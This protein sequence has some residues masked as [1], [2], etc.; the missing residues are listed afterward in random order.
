MWNSVSELLDS[1]RAELGAAGV[2]SWVVEGA[3]ALLLLLGGLLLARLVSAW[4]GRASAARLGVQQSL[5]L[6]R[7]VFLTLA[8]LFVATAL[9]QL[10]F[11]L[12][13]LLGAAGVLTVAVGFASQTSASN[14]ISGLFLISE[15]T[16]EVGDVIRVGAITGE[17]LAVDLLSVKLRRFDNTYVRIPN[18]KMI[19]SDVETLTRFRI[20]RI[21]L[22]LRVGFDEDIDAVRACLAAV[23][24]RHPKCL[25]EPAP[26]VQLKAFGESGLDVQLSVW[27]AKEN[28][29]E[30]STELHES[31]L[32][33]LRENGIRMPV[34]RRQLELTTPLSADR[35]E[36]QPSG[37][38]P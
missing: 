3:R 35:Y 37:D 16:F 27:V 26:L 28:F 24:R 12:S 34:P 22:L 25:S 1:L 7:G 31:V 23:P 5:L 38:G 4:V 9:K 20:R 21:D 6:K 15:R 14:L 8:G 17:V 33:S 10:G 32:L 2:I 13:L 30:I 18:E 36:V 11:D 19:K 29:V